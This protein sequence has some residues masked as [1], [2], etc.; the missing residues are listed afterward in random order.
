MRKTHRQYFK[1][2]I[3]C[4]LMVAVLASLAGCG[5]QES[6]NQSSKSSSKD[7]TLVVLS[8][9]GAIQDAQRKAI[10][11]PFEKKYGV[12]IIEASPVDYGKIKAMVQNGKM[13][14]DVMDVDTDFVP[15]GVKE[16]LLQKLDFNVIDKTDLDPT[17]VS[18]YSVGAETYTTGISYNTKDFSVSNHPRTWAD[19]WNVQKYPGARCLQKWPLPTLEIALLADGV[20][21]QHL[22]PLDVDRAFRSLDKI[23]KYVKVWWDTGA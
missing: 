15:R 10:F 5:A 2:L 19:F 8:W 3:V 11:E 17:Y 12:K 6:S 22:Y 16:K 9:G 23:K 20:D 7:K 4:L 13:E 21:P 14:Y 1:Q 18:D